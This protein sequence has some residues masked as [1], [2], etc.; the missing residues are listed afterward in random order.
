MNRDSRET[1]PR[2]EFK[3]IRQKLN[4]SLDQFAIELGY[5][6]SRQG[7]NKTMRRFESGQRGIPLTL[8]KLVWLLDQHGLP[9]SWPVEL[10][11][12]LS[13]IPE[14]EAQR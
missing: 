11:A 6:G 5:E 9:D 13:D 10:E 2:A 4:L 14:E 12:K 7:N 8:G 3:R 1:M